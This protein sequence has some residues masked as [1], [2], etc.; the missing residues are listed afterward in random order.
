MV[1]DTNTIIVGS[2]PAVCMLLFTIIGLK[3]KVPDN[4]TGALQHFAAGLLLSAVGS[5]LLPT[6]LKANGIKENLYA[7]V[8]F[9]L[10]MGVLII[11]GALL[12]EAHSHGGSDDDDDH[13]HDEH[14][15]DDEDH[16]KRRSSASLRALIPLKP[17]AGSSNSER[18]SLRQAAKAINNDY[19][20]NCDR[21][22]E[23]SGHDGHNS[24]HDSDSG[25]GQPLLISS[26]S[27][28][29]QKQKKE[30]E[31]ELIAVVNE[32][33][34][35]MSFLAA[36]IVDSFMDG[37]LIG[38]T[39][40]AGPSASIIMAGSLSVEMSF[41][42]LTLATA[43]HGMPYRKS[44]PAALA[45]PIFLILGAALGGML[46]T[47]VVD[48]PSMMAGIMGFGTSALL[49]MV[50]EE[51]LLEAHEDGEH[52]WWVDVQLYTGKVIVT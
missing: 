36:V 48:N 41:V 42:G 15:D 9:F 26:S 35:P 16:G 39:G 25:E 6:L 50:A 44:I 21:I 43:C 52:I 7:T 33:A 29:K 20:T 38:I 51:L 30:E 11:L 2:V 10:G 23:E 47:Q 4:I 13:D 17:P 40:A 19:C 22:I 3:I 37:F 46:A 12:P 45:G 14:G 34:L 27:S 5:E 32:K 31:A 18:L 24:H 49:F 1:L 28:S 8:G